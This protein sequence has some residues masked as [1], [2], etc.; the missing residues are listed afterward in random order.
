MFLISTTAKADYDGFIGHSITEIITDDKSPTINGSYDDIGCTDVIIQIFDDTYNTNANGSLYS[1]SSA[2]GQVAVNTMGYSLN[3]TLDLRA[4]GFGLINGNYNVRALYKCPGFNGQY[5]HPA[6]APVF[7]HAI[8]VVPSICLD[9]DCVPVYRIYNKERG[10]HFY[11]TS[12]Y[13]MVELFKF[14]WGY[15]Y[16]GIASYAP[17]EAYIDTT[18]IHRFYNL[19]YGNHFYTSSQ[20]E[21]TH[22]NDTMSHTYRYEG[23][24][25]NTYIENLDASFTPVHRF[26]KFNQ[27]VHFFTS[28]QAE[29]TAVNNTMGNIYRYEDVAYYN[30]RNE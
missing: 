11:T 28:N 9:I 21:A 29:A 4:N 14:N 25:Y 19:K 12:E 3:W 16:E 26:Y 6:T 13:E 8:S 18:P 27:G 5:S 10:T 22:I 24:A 23:V 7:K 17:S 30:I 15:K 2:L 1:F 20:S